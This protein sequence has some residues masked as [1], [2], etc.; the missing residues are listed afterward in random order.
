MTTTTRDTAT[1]SSQRV[2]RNALRR[3]VLLAGVLIVIT[4]I[5]SMAAEFGPSATPVPAR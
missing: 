1:A 2:S 4:Y 5:T 3:T